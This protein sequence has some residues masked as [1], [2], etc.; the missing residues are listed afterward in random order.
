MGYWAI[1]AMEEHRRVL[2]ESLVAGLE[3][4]SRLVESAGIPV[5]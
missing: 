2:A 1:V 4:L 3:G 5:S